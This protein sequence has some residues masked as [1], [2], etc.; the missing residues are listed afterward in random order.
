[1]PRHA[2]HAPAAQILPRGDRPRHATSQLAGRPGGP[3]GLTDEPEG[4][5][6]RRSRRPDGSDDRPGESDGRPGGSAGRPGGSDGR[7]GGSAG[8]GDGAR[9]PVEGGRERGDCVLGGGVLAPARA[10]FVP[11]GR[12]GVA[13]GAARASRAE[14]VGHG[15]ADVF[16]PGGAEEGAITQRGGARAGGRSL[17]PCRRGMHS[18]HALHGLRDGQS[19]VA[20]PVATT[21]GPVG[22]EDRRSARAGG[23]SF[24]AGEVPEGRHAP[25]A[26][27]DQHA[28]GVVGGLS[29]GN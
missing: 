26:S 4:R 23:G 24:R 28:Y 14:P 8:G 9:R 3:A 29:H 13:T 19:T 27:A 10:A 16:C 11:E 2:S 5:P 20:P 1:M 18:T 22:A 17:R 21:P 15:R 7:P 25:L 6:G 12:R